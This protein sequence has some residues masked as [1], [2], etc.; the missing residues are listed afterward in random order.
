MRDLLK[1]SRARFRKNRLSF[2]AISS[3]TVFLLGFGLVYWIWH[4]FTLVASIECAYALNWLEGWFGGR[5]PLQLIFAGIV[6][7][8]LVWLLRLITV[9]PLNRGEAAFQLIFLLGLL[10][11]FGAQKAYLFPNGFPSRAQLERVAWFT[12]W[13]DLR[14]VEEKDGLID[15]REGWAFDYPAPPFAGRPEHPWLDKTFNPT[16]MDISLSENAPT[17]EEMKRLNACHATYQ[18]AL[19]QYERDLVLWEEYVEGFRSW[20]I[21]NEWRLIAEGK[22]YPRQIW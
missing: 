11:A 3:F 21:E 22:E 6:L 12:G 17:E 8:T 16:M 9:R 18:A 10:G 2:P 20:Y 19:R 4:M 13:G 7:S 1:L 5:A 14:L 15:V